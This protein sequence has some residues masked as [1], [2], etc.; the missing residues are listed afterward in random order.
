MNNYANKFENLNKMNKFLEKVTK[1]D[2]TIDKKLSPQRKLYSF[3]GNNI[4]PIQ[5]LPENT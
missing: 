2:T 3:K 5:S 4:N 1:T